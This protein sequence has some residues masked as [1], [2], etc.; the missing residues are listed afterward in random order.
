MPLVVW[1]IRRV[2]RFEHC[3]VIWHVKWAT[4]GLMP[5]KPAIVLVNTIEIPADTAAKV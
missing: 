2:C 1:S 5:V 3:N 4:K